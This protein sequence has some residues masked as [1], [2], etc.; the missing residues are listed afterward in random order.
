MTK[1][2]FGYDGS[3]DRKTTREEQDRK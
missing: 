3:N 2:G 1:N